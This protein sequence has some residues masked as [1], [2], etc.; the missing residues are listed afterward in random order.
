M[1]IG[2]PRIA[3]YAPLLAVESDDARRE[4]IQRALGPHESKGA[5]RQVTRALSGK[6][7]GD[8]KVAV[9]ITPLYMDFAQVMACG[10]RVGQS[11][12]WVRH[13]PIV[14]T[15]SMSWRS[16]SWR[17]IERGVR[18]RRRCGLLRMSLVL[19]SAPDGGS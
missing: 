4:R 10:Y 3:L 16:R 11:F 8:L 13:D 7:H 14:T 1:E 18:C 2:V 19:T 6:A 15:E 17:T 9:L 12:D 5:P